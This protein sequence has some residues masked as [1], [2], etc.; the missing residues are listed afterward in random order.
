MSQAKWA[1]HGNRGG[2]EL[3]LFVSQPADLK[4]YLQSLSKVQD[5]LEKDPTGSKH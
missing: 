3:K 1:R 2:I 4:N 5:L